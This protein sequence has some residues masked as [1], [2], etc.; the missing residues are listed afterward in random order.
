MKV[1]I[2][3]NYFNDGNM[4]SLEHLVNSSL[5]LRAPRRVMN[6]NLHKPPAENHFKMDFRKMYDF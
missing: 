2:V 6:M 3:A 1:E 5:V 4:I